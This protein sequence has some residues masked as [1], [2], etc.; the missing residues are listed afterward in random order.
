[1]RGYPGQSELQLVVCFSDGARM[2]MACENLRIEIGAELR[3]RVDDLLGPGNLKPIA[4]PPKP[5]P[6][7][8]QRRGGNGAPAMARR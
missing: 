4:A 7:P 1:V 2:M 5:A 8:P 6:P 3:A